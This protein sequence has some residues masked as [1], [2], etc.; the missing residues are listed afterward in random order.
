MVNRRN[1]AGPI[2]VKPERYINE[3]QVHGLIILKKFGWRLV[4]IRRDED[5]AS[6]VIM[7]NGFDGLIGLL[8]LDGVL[9]ISQDLKVRKNGVYDMNMSDDSLP[10]ILPI[11][12]RQLQTKSELISRKGQY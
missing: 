11:F 9:R 12:Y 8:Q 4:C 7:K 1:G 2:P 6:S 3:L 10:E 5:T